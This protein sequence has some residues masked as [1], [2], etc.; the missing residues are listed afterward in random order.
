MQLPD[1][2]LEPCSKKKKQSTPRKFL[3]FQETET[4]KKFFM[5]QETELFYISGNGTF[6]YFRKRN[7]LIF[8]ETELSYI[9]GKVYSEP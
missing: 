3:I 4:P 9:E 6:L 5:F 1:A 8:Q 2:L 7:S